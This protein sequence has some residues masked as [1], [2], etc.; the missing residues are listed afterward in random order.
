MSVLWLRRVALRLNP[1]DSPP[2]R[3]LSLVL[4][5]LLQCPT[6]RVLGPDRVA[7]EHG[8]ALVPGDPG[9]VEQ[10][11]P[12]VHKVFRHLAPSAVEVWSLDADHSRQLARASPVTL[13]GVLAD[14]LSRWG[15]KDPGAH[16]A[17]PFQCLVNL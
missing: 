1:D 5:E 9:G 3:L 10:V 17:A 7:L 12:G 2:L 8:Q 4:G 11:R 6:L 13:H 14:L 15:G 16:D